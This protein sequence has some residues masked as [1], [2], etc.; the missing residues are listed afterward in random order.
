VLRVELKRRRLSTAKNRKLRKMLAP[1]K[2]K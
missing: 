1:K 2:R